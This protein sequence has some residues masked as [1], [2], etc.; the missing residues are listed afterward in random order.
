VTSCREAMPRRVEQRSSCQRALHEVLR[1]L[2]RALPES[3]E[4]CGA[5]ATRLLPIDCG[6]PDQE[7][8]TLTLAG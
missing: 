4:R 5:P 6:Y 7:L 1:G 2:R 8:P 3:C